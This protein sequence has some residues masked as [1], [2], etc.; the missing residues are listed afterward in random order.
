MGGSGSR[1]ASLGAVIFRLRPTGWVGAKGAAICS[2]R[3]KELLRKPCTRKE[4]GEGREQKEDPWNWMG[5][6]DSGQLEGPEHKV[7]VG[8]WEEQEGWPR[9]SHR[10]PTRHLLWVME[11]CPPKKICQSPNAIWLVPLRKGVNLDGPTPHG[12]HHENVK[13]ETGVLHLQVK[14]CSRLP[15]ATRRQ[16]RDKEQILLHSP[17]KN[18]PYNTSTW[19]FRPL[20]L[21]ASG[22]SGLSDFWPPGLWDNAFLSLKLPS[23]WYSVTAIL[24]N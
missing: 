5:S 15:R 11:L 8:S 12:E 6:E 19:D 2:S 1:E 23:L 16:K 14:E 10:G 9:Q 20:G 21:S 7:F 4:V 17:G 13:V 24:A 22:T 18:Q 3:R